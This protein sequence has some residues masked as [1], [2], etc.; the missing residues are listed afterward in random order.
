MRAGQWKTWGIILIGVGV[1]VWMTGFLGNTYIRLVTES[2]TNVSQSI[3]DSNSAQAT[4]AQV[5]LA[6]LNYWTC[7]VGV[8][9]SEENARIEKSR[10][11]QMGWETQI[12]SQN[13]W[14]VGIGFAHEQE[15]LNVLRERLKEGGVENVV[16]HFVIP[17]QAYKISGSGAEQTA[18][19]LS[20]VQ[21]FLKTSPGQRENTLIL[22]E[23]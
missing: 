3:T 18:Q 14:I 8:F 19:I 9:Q 22:L 20:A 21:N 12:V 6:E 4:E 10:L 2:R 11:E 5:S 23:K 15:E 1:L 13:P 16:K 17:E 7:Q